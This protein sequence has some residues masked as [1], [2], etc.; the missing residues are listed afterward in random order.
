MQQSNGY[1]P[2]T[3][4][5]NVYELQ[6]GRSFEYVDDWG[7]VFTKVAKDGILGLTWQGIPIINRHMG[8]NVP[9]G[10]GSMPHQLLRSGLDMWNHQL[11]FLFTYP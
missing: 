8:I 1:Y 6:G 11:R 4:I 7:N 9:L 3:A 2:A 10:S 5:M